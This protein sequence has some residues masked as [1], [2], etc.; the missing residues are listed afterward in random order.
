MPEESG[1][2]QV[3]STSQWEH[4]PNKLQESK[5]WWVNVLDI[6]ALR[7]SLGVEINKTK[8]HCKNTTEDKKG[9]G[10]ACTE[11]VVGDCSYVAALFLLAGTQREN[12]RLCFQY[13]ANFLT[14]PI[15]LSH[16]F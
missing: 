10:S 8:K 3:T 7:N 14:H 9:P 4:E 16:S 12:L 1:I 2:W 5:Q 11:K 13:P 15:F 6:N